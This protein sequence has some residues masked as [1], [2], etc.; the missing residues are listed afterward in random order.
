[1]GCIQPGFRV[2]GS[3]KEGFFGFR[4]PFQGGSGVG[5]VEEGL[6]FRVRFRVLAGFEKDLIVRLF[7]WGYSRIIVYHI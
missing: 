4:V 5:F 2:R 7:F 6:G 1:M 3:F